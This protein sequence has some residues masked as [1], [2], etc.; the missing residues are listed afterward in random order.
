MCWCFIKV[1]PEHLRHASDT[2]R[3]EAQSDGRE[4][5]GIKNLVAEGQNL[6]GN[7][8]GPHPTRGST[9][10]SRCC[11]RFRQL[12]WNLPMNGNRKV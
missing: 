12:L 5:L 3:A 2:E 1:S 10:P 11:N 8:C 9:Q 7:Q 4:L 6:L